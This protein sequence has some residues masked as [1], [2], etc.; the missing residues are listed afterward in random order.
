MVLDI[1]VLEDEHRVDIITKS[2]VEGRNKG[3]ELAFVDGEWPL[4]VW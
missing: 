3:K 2:V 4:N 1:D